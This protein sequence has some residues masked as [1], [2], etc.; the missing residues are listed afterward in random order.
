MIGTL[1][2]H[3]ELTVSDVVENESGVNKIRRPP[4]SDKREAND[5]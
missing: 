1:V 5:R 3:G 4:A 2:L